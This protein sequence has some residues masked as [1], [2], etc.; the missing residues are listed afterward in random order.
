MQMFKKEADI[1]VYLVNHPNASGGGYP[2]SGVYIAV[3]IVDGLISGE[4][5]A[6]DCL[7]NVTTLISCTSYFG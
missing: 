2:L 5:T 1:L 7:N 4:I 3:E 6:N